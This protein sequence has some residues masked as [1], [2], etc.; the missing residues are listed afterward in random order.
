MSQSTSQWGILPGPVEYVGR[1]G[2]APPVPE[3]ETLAMLALGFGLVTWG[4]RRKS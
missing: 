2:I 3:P 1:L 4:A